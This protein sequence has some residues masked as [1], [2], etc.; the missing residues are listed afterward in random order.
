MARRSPLD[1]QPGHVY[2]DGRRARRVQLSREFPE[3]IR[4]TIDVILVRLCDRGLK[5]A[6]LTGAHQSKGANARLSG[7]A[8]PLCT[9]LAATQT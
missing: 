9:K 6:T 8:H 2:T 5:V 3:L 4:Q 7:T 1:V